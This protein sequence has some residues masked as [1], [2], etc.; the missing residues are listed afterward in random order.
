MPWLVGLAV[1]GF[2]ILLTA[3]VTHNPVAAALAVVVGV[4]ISV[5][6]ARAAARPSR[7]FR[8]ENTP[9]INT[10]RAVGLFY[11]ATGVVWAAL[12]VMAAFTA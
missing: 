1:L 8:L 10:T 4:A 9:M 7:P 11:V 6:G 5:I 2:L 12:A 3:G